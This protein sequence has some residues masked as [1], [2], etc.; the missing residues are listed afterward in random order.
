MMKSPKP[1]QTK[2]AQL[3]CGQLETGVS[4]F[5][6]PFLYT[7]HRLILKTPKRGPGHPMVVKNKP[8]IKD[9]VCLAPHLPTHQ[10]GES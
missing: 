8:G 6:N 9:V 10:H 5:E 2:Q 7:D 3:G 4:D 1:N